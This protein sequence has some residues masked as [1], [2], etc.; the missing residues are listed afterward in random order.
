MAASVLCEE[1]KKPL[2]IKLPKKIQVNMKQR[3]TRIN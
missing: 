1:K 3:K 2:E